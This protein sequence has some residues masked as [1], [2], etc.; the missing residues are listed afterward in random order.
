MVF[1]VSGQLQQ[2]VP[3]NPVLL[4][5]QEMGYDVSKVIELDDVY[6]VDGDLV[7]SKNIYDYPKVINNSRQINTPGL[8]SDDNITITVFSFLSETG[9]PPPNSYFTALQQAVGFW[10]AARG[11]GCAPLF[12][13]VTTNNPNNPPDIIIRG[14][15]QIGGWPTGASGI[16]GRVQSEPF[17]G[18][19]FPF[20][21][22]NTNFVFGP[23]SPN[24]NCP[25]NSLGMPGLPTQVD[26]TNII[27]H[28]LGHAI[29]FSHTNTGGNQ[30][31]GTPT[32]DDDSVMDSRIVECRRS[33]TG[34]SGGDVAAVQAVYGCNSDYNDNAS[35]NGIIVISDLDDDH[36]CD[37]GTFDVSGT[38]ENCTGGSAQIQLCFE[39][40][41]A[42][43]TALCSSAT[44]QTFNNGTFFYQNLSSSIIPNYN[45]GTSYKISARLL[46]EFPDAST[47]LELGHNC[48]GTGSLCNDFP[49]EFIRN[50]SKQN[51]YKLVIDSNDDII[52]ANVN[53]NISVDL[54]GTI[55]TEEY[56]MAKYSS[57]GCLL[58]SVGAPGSYASIRLD[59]N[60]NIYRIDPTSPTVGNSSITK[61]SPDGDLLWS[62]NFPSFS[63]WYYFEMNGNNSYFSAKNSNGFSNR[64]FKLDND[65]GTN[66]ELNSGLPSEGFSI[67]KIFISD[68]TN[69]VSVVAT[70]GPEPGY[71]NIN[72]FT[73]GLNTITPPSHST[74]NPLFY[75]KDIYLLK[76]SLNP[77]TNNLTPIMALQI[78]TTPSDVYFDESLNRLFIYNGG[79]G[80]LES[81]DHDYSSI[82]SIVTIS[83]GLMNL[84]QSS[85][86]AS[87]IANDGSSIDLISLQSL[88][89][90]FTNL[91][92]PNI[93]NKYSRINHD[94]ASSSNIYVSWVTFG[95]WNMNFQK[96]DA[97]TG[98]L[99]ARSSE[100]Q[101]NELIT[102]EN[103]IEKS[104][105]IYPNPF[106]DYI[107]IS[108]EKNNKILKI[109][110]IDKFGT[111]LLVCKSKNLIS[112]FY[113]NT[114]HLSRGMYFIKIEYI[115]GISTVKQIVKD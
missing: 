19:P 90:N 65:N 113:L 89:G 20:I 93:E 34:L 63:S 3:L 92:I 45:P 41:G 55:V 25:P 32:I 97:N 53:A 54:D 61:Y 79:N 68:L 105:S 64:I 8:V 114:K 22:I 67:S 106:D 85:D 108:Q 62:S 14:P 88:F 107:N 115:N 71:T 2:V 75:P 33:I 96:I 12:Q 102:E 18:R 72:P 69:E 94:I 47:M 103:Q 16:Y 1:T 46:G 24:T 51:P 80:T 74:S 43:G 58:W 82:G 23:P 39:E 50:G 44:L 42:T 10:N 84:R 21:D 100:K 27:T 104:L 70:V 112:D 101:E 5:I 17:C 76:Y 4:K 91:N 95:T 99:L 56:F 13:I 109:S 7:F 9:I 29:G 11:N 37:D 77:L 6:L 31:P 73:F 30:I 28:E 81:L 87:I 66:I 40:V 26:M 60:D 48:G 15:N 49:K 98:N 57:N 110:V 78:D 111:T 35:N 59:D 38:F 86:T 83:N 52:L 36:F